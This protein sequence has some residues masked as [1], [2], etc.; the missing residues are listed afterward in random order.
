MS[1]SKQ[2]RLPLSYTSP[3]PLA[4]GKKLRHATTVDKSAPMIEGKTSS[5]SSGGGGGMSGM[6]QGIAAM[7]AA[8][9][10]VNTANRV[11][12]AIGLGSKDQAAAAGGAGHG[13]A[14]GGGVSMQDA[15]NMMASAPQLGSLFANGMPTLRKAGERASG[16]S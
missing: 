3:F 11:H 2:R 9:S 1:P 4:A 8:R 10:A 7:A 12:S 13:S 16:Q 15:R 14:G 5:S 6:Q